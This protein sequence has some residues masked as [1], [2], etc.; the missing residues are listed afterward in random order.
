MKK[1]VFFVVLFFTVT[2]VC[3]FIAFR[4]APNAGRLLTRF[5][6]SAQEK[7]PPLIGETY[8]EDAAPTDKQKQWALAT[9]AIRTGMNG[10]SHDVL[11]GQTEEDQGGKYILSKWWD[12]NSREDLLNVLKS[13]ERGGHRKGYDEWVRRLDHLSPEKRGQ[14]RRYAAHAGG[15]TSNRMDTVLSTRKKLAGTGLAGWDFSRYVALCGWGFQAKYL[16][17]QEAWSFIMPIARLLQNTFSSWDELADNY[18]EGRRFWSLR[19]TLREAD[20]LKEEVAFLRW[21]PFSPWARLKWKTNLLPEG[22]KDDG[23][24]EFREGK[25]WY[26]GFGNRTYDKGMSKAKAAKLFTQAAEKGNVDAMF[27]LG[28]CHMWGEGVATNK[29]E[30]CN[31]YRKA[32]ELG[33]GPSQYELGMC[34]FRGTGVK[35]DL[36]KVVELMTQAVTNG[37]GANAE[38]CLGYCYE[39]GLGVDKSIGEAVKW[40]QKGADNGAAW[41]QVNIG[42]CYSNGHGVE[43]SLFKAAKWFEKSAIGGHADGMF[44]WAECLENGSGTVKNEAEALKWYRKAAENGCGKAKKRLAEIERTER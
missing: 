29:T 14:F 1:I 33:D 7:Y 38:A 20:S 24:A 23:S 41:A 3:A 35:K 32:A 9:C 39:E 8:P 10:C 13:L 28:L 43:R 6:L 4:F 44:N 26:F 18:V 34:Y 2:L 19:E 31:W 42:D 5:A 12:V 17:E 40:Y 30:A 37:G 25:S 22:H 36:K 11:G 16:S 27:W 21:N 15:P